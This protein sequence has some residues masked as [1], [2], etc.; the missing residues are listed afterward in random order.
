M[1]IELLMRYDDN[2]AE[3]GD[4]S[5]LRAKDY[6]ARHGYSLHVSRLAQ[7]AGWGPYWMKV[8]LAQE[9]LVRGGADYLFWMD[10]DSFIMDLAFP[11]ESLH[12]PEG[13]LLDL[14][15]ESTGMCVGAMGVVN[16]E[17][18]RRLLDTWLFLGPMTKIPDGISQNHGGDQAPLMLLDRHFDSVHNAIHRIPQEFI[19]NPETPEKGKFLHLF[20]TR[21][22]G[23]Q[24]NVRQMRDLLKVSSVSQGT[25]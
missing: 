12:G 15:T 10:A 3:L 8:F 9:R 2:Y 4:I 19:S 13:T 23:K 25:I 17:W 6:A 21:M 16:C 7:P 14:P 20:W 1:T 5:S 18:T 24:E 22:F 11:L